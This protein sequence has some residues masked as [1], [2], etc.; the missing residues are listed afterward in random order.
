MQT[1]KMTLTDV[2]LQALNL[3]MENGSDLAQ[4]ISRIIR[5][6]L[7]RDRFGEDIYHLNQTRNGQ[8]EFMP[9]V[10]RDSWAGFAIE[11]GKLYVR[12][13]R[14]FSPV[15]LYKATAWSVKFRVPVYWGKQWYPTEQE[16]RNVDI[17]SMRIPNTL[18]FDARYN[19]HCEVDTQ[20]RLRSQQPYGVQLGE[21]ETSMTNRPLDWPS[22][23]GTHTSMEAPPQPPFLPGAV[24]ITRDNSQYT[25]SKNMR[26]RMASY[27]RIHAPGITDAQIETIQVKIWDLI[28]QAQH[29]PDVQEHWGEEIV[30]QYIDTECE[31]CMAGERAEN[32]HVDFYA[33]NPDFVSLATV[34][35]DSFSEGSGRALIWHTPGGPVL[36]RIYTEGG[37]EAAVFKAAVTARYPE[38]ITANQVPSEEEEAV[39]YGMKLRLPENRMLPYMDNLSFTEI[40]PDGDDVILF[41]V[42][43]RMPD[44]RWESNSDYQYGGRF[45]CKKLECHSCGDCVN[46]E[47]HY[48]ELRGDPDRPFCRSCYESGSVAWVEST[49][50]YMVEDD[51]VWSEHM[52]EYIPSYDATHL[53]APIDSYVLTDDVDE[54]IEDH[55]RRRPEDFLSIVREYLENH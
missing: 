43:R 8:G 53:G 52:E 11:N 21:D 26:D 2:Q 41:C 5:K 29:V 27:L 38:I 44:G 6:D 10:S 51:V 7:N 18:S 1:N 35:E 20:F 37:L 3:R 50:E 55:M 14:T 34:E 12:Y 30:Q 25:A 9:C 17:E 42:P 28:A 4:K 39:K 49:N 36:D 45:A 24:A 54:I 15:L 32:G 19:Y 13:T 23:V 46:E 40:L 48:G 31:S 33:A 22:Y 16:W 47:D